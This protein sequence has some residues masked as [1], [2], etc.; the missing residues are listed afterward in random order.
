[1]K[2]NVLS[3]LFFQERKSEWPLHLVAIEMG[4]HRANKI[5]EL[6]KSLEDSKKV[7]FQEIK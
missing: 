3:L 2:I 4:G 6:F 5:E 7:A 1:M